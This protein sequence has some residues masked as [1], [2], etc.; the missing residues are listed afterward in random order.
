MC[1]PSPVF[2]VNT[3]REGKSVILKSTK[4]QKRKKI[5]FF[6]ET[7]DGFILKFFNTNT[8]NE[9][10][11]FVGYDIY[12]TENLK[13]STKRNE[14][15]G[16]NV[17][18]TNKQVWGKVKKINTNSLNKFLE[19]QNEDEILFVP[20][21]ETIIKKIDKKKALIIIDP[22]AGLKNLNQK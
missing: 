6:K 9:A 1:H 21:N 15:I 4:Y 12:S 5:E 8:I 22:P 3:I 13:K 16:F 20:F 19:I 17:E 10:L 11:K 7:N 14:I 18:D 2:N